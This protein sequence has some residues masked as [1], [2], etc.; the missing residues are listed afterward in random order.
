MHYQDVM[1]ILSQCGLGVLLLSSGGEILAINEAGESLLHGKG[2]LNGKRLEDIAPSLCQEAPPVLYANIAFGEYLARCPSPEISNLPQH[3]QLIVFRN[4]TNDAC[5]DML[6]SV[7]NQINESVV[8]CDAESRIYLLN[9]AAVRL[10][11]MVTRD[12]LG[13][14]VSSV[15]QALNVEELA[16]PQV[17]R[18]KRPKL[19]HRQHYAT[20]YGREVNTVNNTYPIAQNGQLLGAFNISEDWS[21][22]D[23]LHKQVIDL[24]EK[25]TGS[26]SPGNP[27]SRNVLT[28][29]YQFSD[30]IYASP[31]VNSVVTQCKR[32]AKTDS[33]AML[34][35]ETGTGKELFA[36]SI[37]NAS[38]RA[39]GPFLAI[40]CAALP[41]NLLESLLFGTEKGA[42]TGAERRAGLFEQA[43]HG[44]LLL[45][46]LNSMNIN[47]QSKL[48]RVLQD[49][50]VRR[51]GGLSEIRVDV[52]VL[53]NVNIPPYQAIA[54]NK[55]RQ[56][57]FYRLG[58]VNINIPPLRKRKE[59][60]ALL[61][62]HF[63]IKYN[64]TLAKNVKNI[65]TAVLDA[66]F[67]YDW[68]GNV[69]ELQHA[70][71]HAMNILPD[72]LS[73]IQLE[74]IP[75]HIIG[76]QAHAPR[77][78]A[79]AAAAPSAAPNSLNASM[80]DLEYSTVC[81]ALLECG[82]NVSRAAHLLQISRQN[83]QYRIKKYQI[84]I[85]A[86]LHADQ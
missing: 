65:S 13:E 3:T 64:K 55:L 57:L 39:D 44:T 49:G 68:P 81:K 54:E 7:L 52:R 42:Y 4:A 72:D 66:F 29:K 69:R 1:K 38:N 56:D 48:L 53:S 11:S 41:E 77:E 85:D 17:I 22:I 37:H 21:T 80:Q 83:L 30:I 43:N 82:G 63:I 71:E 74:H 5:H 18:E 47:L 24:R 27:K 16:I 14:N 84:N 79:I 33:S 8:L 62:K 59:D 76:N 25:L 28:A 67:E 34:Y 61:A 51:V 19:N 78:T 70:I 31:A 2:S 45:D 75:E 9:D 10:D 35:G 58:V 12:V 50:V 6:V 15:Y 40:N 26:S 32:I 46:E 60:I 36:Q 73:V 20:R 86:L 23:D